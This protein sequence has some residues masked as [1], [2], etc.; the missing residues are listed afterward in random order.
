[1]KNHDQVILINL[2]SRGPKDL[3]FDLLGTEGENPYAATGKD[4]CQ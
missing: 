4:I 2:H 1:V 3:D